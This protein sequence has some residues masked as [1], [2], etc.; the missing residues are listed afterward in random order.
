[1][2]YVKSCYRPTITDEHLKS[3][4]MIGT[5]NCEP[6]LDVIQK[7]I[8]FMYHTVGKAMLIVTVV[9]HHNL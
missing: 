6:Q 5:T 8:S 9:Q 1:M 3:Q 4:L 2:K 7:R